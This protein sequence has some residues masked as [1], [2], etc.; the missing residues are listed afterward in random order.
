VLA[1][2]SERYEKVIAENPD[3]KKEMDLARAS[4]VQRGQII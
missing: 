2:F 3:A 4:V 1:S